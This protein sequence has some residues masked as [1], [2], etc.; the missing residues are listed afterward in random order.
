MGGL[1]DLLTEISSASER[2]Y[3]TE[4]RYAPASRNPAQGVSRER[5]TPRISQAVA[6]ASGEDTEGRPD[7]PE[8]AEQSMPQSPAMQTETPVF[9]EEQL[10]SGIIM[11]EI[12]G[13]P[14]SKRKGRG[15][16]GLDD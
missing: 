10:I 1:L 2:H 16:F 7:T 3:A 15:R 5:I 4:R 14:V 11:A 12:L 9:S 6:E 8:T 13:R